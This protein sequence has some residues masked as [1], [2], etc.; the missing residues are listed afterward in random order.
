MYDENLT[1]LLES[2]SNEELD[3]L[4]NFLL[5]PRSSLLAKD[6]DYLRL[7]PDHGRYLGAIVKEIRLF[8]GHTIKDRVVGSPGRAWRAIV[9]DAL[10]E[11]GVKAP[12]LALREMEHTVVKLALDSE[13]DNLD[14]AAQDKLL[15]GFYRG[16]L[17]RSG[18]SQRTVL[19]DFIS[20][21]E[22]NVATPELETEKVKRVLGQKAVGFV[23]KTIKG[24]A[25]STGLKLVLRGAAAPIGV[26]LTA[27]DLLGP[28]YRVTIPVICYIAYLRHKHGT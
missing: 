27:W 15:D 25:V 24:K 26:G 3:P 11:L 9:R 17:F 19:D 20:R 4:V 5:E 16:S 18:L 1:P 21:A 14:K 2:C 23:K 6:P 22:G 10:L 13:F 28:A 8:G 12:P 7:N